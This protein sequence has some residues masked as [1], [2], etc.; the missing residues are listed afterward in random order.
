M[1]AALTRGQV[2]PAEAGTHTRPRR[3]RESGNPHKPR[4]SRESG[5]PASS[6]EKQRRWVPASAGTTGVGV[7]TCAGT[8]MVV[9]RTGPG[10]SSGIPGFLDHA[11]ERILEVARE[12]RGIHQ[13]RLPHPIAQCPA[14]VAS[15]ARIRRQ[16][17]I[18]GNV[19]VVGL[20]DQFRH[21]EGGQDTYARTCHRARTGQRN[22][23]NFHP[24]NVERRRATVI[25]ESVERDVDVA[26]R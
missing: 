17:H 11:P 12:S 6:G 14:Q 20:R 3:S 21:A 18:E 16:L 10:A 13:R 4:R 7:R 2:V 23:R 19:L 24:E 9:V 22:Q 25:G 8:T 1:F 15:P 5:N 26:N